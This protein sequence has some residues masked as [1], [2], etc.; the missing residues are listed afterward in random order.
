MSI[1]RLTYVQFKFCVQGGKVFTYFKVACRVQI[2]KKHFVK[3][4]TIFATVL[5]KM[6]YYVYAFA[7]YLQKTPL[8][9]AYLKL[10]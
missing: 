5:L 9:Q 8:F 10:H 1:E 3:T 6:T 2:W 7:L 4:V